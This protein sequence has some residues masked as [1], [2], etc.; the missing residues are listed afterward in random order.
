MKF[1]RKLFRS[2]S[3]MADETTFVTKEAK[4]AHYS[5]S[6]PDYAHLR[7]H[8]RNVLRNLLVSSLQLLYRE[9]YTPICS[10]LLLDIDRFRHINLS[11]GYASGDQLLKEIADRLLVA[12]D[13]RL[14]IQTGDDE[15]VLLL[16]ADNQ[17][18][19][20]ANIDRIQQVF[21]EPFCM[22]SQSC[23]V[24][25]SVGIS[26]VDLEEHSVDLALKQADLALRAAKNTGKNKSLHY[27]PEHEK[28]NAA[29]YIQ[30]ETELRK[31]IQEDQL[32]LYYQ[33]RLELSTGQIICLEALVRWNHPVHGIIPPGEFIP[34]AEE[35]GL[36]LPLGEW[37]LRHACMQKKK[38]LEAGIINYQL[39]VNIS[40]C[41]FQEHD[42]ADKV[43]RVIDQM[44]IDPS[45]LEFEITESTIMHN[46]DKTVSILERLCDY[47]ISISIDDFGIGYSSLSYLKHFP[48]NCL[49][50]DRSFVK[51]IHNNHSDLAITHAIIHLGHTL[52]LQVVAEGVEELSQLEILRETKCNTIQ[53]YLLSPPI[54]AQELELL[55]AC[56]ALSLRQDDE[57]RE[58][59]S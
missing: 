25:A 15:F 59:C 36:I 2:F 24:N 10:L 54:S 52:N 49:K 22:D 19:L 34:L 7:I 47:G 39:A 26:Q 3:S 55:I 32:T 45:F 44:H 57:P 12:N 11:L 43:I 18:E 6:P 31:A 53:G 37:V 40:P 42:F 1:I 46:M 4:E 50:I 28:A 13:R 48:I 9:N 21:L 5:G 41:Q 30:L 14:V 8:D 23:Y 33:P 27:E 35:S 16:H 51:N 20:T 58:E 56:K 29:A 17:Q 38:W